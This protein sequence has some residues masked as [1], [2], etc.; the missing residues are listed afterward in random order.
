MTE[1]HRLVKQFLSISN[2]GKEPLEI[3]QKHDRST[4]HKKTVTSF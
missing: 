2:F 3:M 1:K 4:F